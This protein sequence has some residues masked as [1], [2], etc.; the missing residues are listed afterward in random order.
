[1]ARHQRGVSCL[2]EVDIEQAYHDSIPLDATMREPENQTRLSCAPDNQILF[3]W[4][5][6]GDHV[7]VVLQVA[8]GAESV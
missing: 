1:M 7:L 3:W 8:L 6:S 5:E 4:G 2:A